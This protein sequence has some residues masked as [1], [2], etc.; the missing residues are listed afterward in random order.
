[1]VFGDDTTKTALAEDGWTGRR[2]LGIAW[3]A[4]PEEEGW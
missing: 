1:M 3:R 2:W 4:A